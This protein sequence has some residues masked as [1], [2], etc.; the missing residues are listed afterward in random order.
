MLRLVW[1]MD[2]GAIVSFW[3]FV[4]VSERLSI[5]RIFRFLSAGTR[6][7]ISMVSLA[8]ENG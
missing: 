4:H 5:R 3:K 6:K 8:V 2:T 7:G 1:N